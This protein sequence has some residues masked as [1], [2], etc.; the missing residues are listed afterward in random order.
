[1]Q[2]HQKTAGSSTV[3]S[4]EKQSSRA[5]EL[6]AGELQRVMLPN[7]GWFGAVGW[8]G[9]DAFLGRLP[10]IRAGPPENEFGGGKLPLSERKAGLACPLISF[11]GGCQILCLRGKQIGWRVRS[12]ASGKMRYLM[13]CKLFPGWCLRRVSLAGRVLF[14]G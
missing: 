2:R 3:L 14:I 6:C 9:C 11:L 10:R 8:C 12:S 7:N 13:G 4:T 1:M 5:R